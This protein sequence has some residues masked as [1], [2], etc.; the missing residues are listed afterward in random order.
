[1]LNVLLNAEPTARPIQQISSR[2]KKSSYERNNTKIAGTII[3]QYIY[4]YLF[5][6]LVCDR[7]R[8]FDRT[9]ILSGFNIFIHF[10]ER[11]QLFNIDFQTHF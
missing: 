9:I 5:L 1:M 6:L 7:P 3:K 2:N 10:I 4:I 11:S 8:T